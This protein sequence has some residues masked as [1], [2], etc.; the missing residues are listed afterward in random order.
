M[1]SDK[2][3]LTS[4]HGAS[5]QIG[6]EDDMAIPKAGVKTAAGGAFFSGWMTRL[7]GGTTRRGSVGFNEQGDLP[8]DRL[9][10]DDS[11]S[12]SGPSSSTDLKAMG[13]PIGS[14][15]RKISY[16]EWLGMTPGDDHDTYFY[17]SKFK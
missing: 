12:N 4:G 7:G 6:D 2:K 3:A 5:F 14:R 11:L 9:F 8:P 13:L 1:A 16:S 10:D 17:K 15:D